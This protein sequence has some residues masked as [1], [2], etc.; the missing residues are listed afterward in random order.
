MQRISSTLAPLSAEY[1]TAIDLSITAAQRG[2]KAAHDCS[3]ALERCTADNISTDEINQHV[4]SL[5]ATIGELLPVAT[6]LKDQFLKVRGELLKVRFVGFENRQRLKFVIF[7]TK[8][9]EDIGSQG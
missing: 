7:S 4:A 2:A 9:Y 3:Y 8:G 6:Q 1:K 5:S